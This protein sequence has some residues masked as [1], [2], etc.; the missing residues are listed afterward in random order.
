MIK[1]QPVTVSVRVPQAG[2]TVTLRWAPSETE[3][4]ISNLP[5][6][7]SLTALSLNTD[8]VQVY[9]PKTNDVGFIPRVFVNGL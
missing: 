1:I 3:P 7:Y 4:A 6:G 5:E 8:W 9:Y 2:A